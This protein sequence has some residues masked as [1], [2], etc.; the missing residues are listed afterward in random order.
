MRTYGNFLDMIPNIKFRSVK[1]TFH[2]LKEDFQKIKQSPNVSAF[3]DTTGNT[4]KMPEQQQQKNFVHDSVTKTYKKVPLNLKTSI[5]LETKIIV[6]L[7][8][9]DVRTECIARTPTLFHLKT[10]K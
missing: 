1:D 2:K 8:N 3:A 7:I 5:N 9:L 6:E 4:Y 10:I